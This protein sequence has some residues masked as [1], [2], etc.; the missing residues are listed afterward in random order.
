MAINSPD[1]YT[2]IYCLT[3]DWSRFAA[4]FTHVCDRVLVVGKL[5]GSPKVTSIICDEAETVRQIIDYL[6]CKGRTRPGIFCNMN[7]NELE[8]YRLGY[9]RQAL[10]QAG[11]SLDWI[12]NH[13]FPLTAEQ[14][15]DPQLQHQ[16][17]C[18][19]MTEHLRTHGSEMD[20]I[21]V[22]YSSVAFRE[23]CR[24]VEF[25]VP[26]DILPVHIA[27][28]QW[29]N[30]GETIFAMLDHN[31]SAHF[32]TAFNILEYR[33]ASGKKEPGSWY[34]CQPLGIRETSL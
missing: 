33:Y 16:E 13:I 23:A 5:S 11:V 1:A 30:I 24:A 10:Q 19:Q 22:A 34:F 29:Q 15:S 6:H 9:W 3:T 28:P 14:D 31:I 25:R 8:M 21:V 4:T 2:L 7:E 20:S 32:E 12:Q 26:D 17:M 27:S 18:H